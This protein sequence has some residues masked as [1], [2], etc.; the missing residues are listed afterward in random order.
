MNLPLFGE[1]SPV[2]PQPL[3]LRK[4]SSAE[5]LLAGLVERC[6]HWSGMDGGPACR[7]RID[8]VLSP[9]DVPGERGMYLSWAGVRFWVVGAPALLQ[10]LCGFNPWLGVPAGQ[11]GQG[12]EVSWPLRD[13]VAVLNNF[14]FRRTADWLQP[15][16]EMAVWSSAASDTAALECSIWSSEGVWLD[17]F[18][19]VP[20]AID[21]GAELLP[22]VL[23]RSGLQ[24]REPVQVSA[25]PLA[26]P[27]VV[28]A[29]GLSLG[30]L[31]SLATGDALLFSQSC[32]RGRD[33][34][35]IEFSGGRL[36]V[37][38]LDATRVEVV[39]PVVFSPV[40][41]GDGM[42]DELNMGDLSLDVHD[43]GAAVAG[44]GLMDL[45]VK[46]QAVAAV[47]NL[48]VAELSRLKAGDSLTLDE[49]AQ[50]FVRLLANG[51]E[52]GL[53]ELVDIDGKL[54][55]QLSRWDIQA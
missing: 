33:C 53:G 52:I 31:R 30:Q 10:A 47:L 37:R 9:L 17:R 16:G 25:L 44:G 6:W 35:E 41:K 39:E 36:V 14:L 21:E 22:V 4:R 54:G 55:V 38:L 28:G 27:L 18:W 46:V 49:P 7:I 5:A 51:K 3:S 8:R 26:L 11:G 45:P 40:A 48:S 32:M 20:S 15:A 12:N 1:S 24:V 23:N 42:D 34:V 13:V 50:P 19:I 2:E 29:V 43:G